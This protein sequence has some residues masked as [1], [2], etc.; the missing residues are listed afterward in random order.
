VLGRELDLRLTRYAPETPV[1][2]PAPSLA[3]PGPSVFEDF[4]QAID[5][6]RQPASPARECAEM[7]AI[8]ERVYAAADRRTGIGSVTP[9]LS[10]AD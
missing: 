2:L 6:G 8:I 9:S 1:D 4:L 7:L 5:R 3:D 10:P